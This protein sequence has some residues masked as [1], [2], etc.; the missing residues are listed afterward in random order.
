ML[1]HLIALAGFLIPLGNLI[2][3]LVIWLVKREEFPFVDDQ[4]K[5]SLNFQITSTI[6]GIV[7][8]LS[9]FVPIVG[10]VTWVLV[11]ALAVAVLVLV[12][13]A[14]IKANEGHRYRYPVNVRL[15][16]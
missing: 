12:I 9:V 10:C 14:T 3:P 13:I 6:V 1:C 15:I 2:G 16:Q 4:G 7:L 11:L 8:V 5:E